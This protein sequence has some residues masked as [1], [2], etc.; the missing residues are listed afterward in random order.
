MSIYRCKLMS[1]VTKYQGLLDP[2]NQP[3]FQPV[4]YC[5]GSVYILGGLNLLRPQ[6]VVPLARRGGKLGP[7]Q[8]VYP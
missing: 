1:S 8:G 4:L 7:L 6:G 2:P 5:N 3:F